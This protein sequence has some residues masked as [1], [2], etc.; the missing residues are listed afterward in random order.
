MVVLA[1]TPLPA[2]LEVAEQIRATCAEGIMVT[3]GGELRITTS[4]GVA[5][6]ASRPGQPENAEDILRRAD[7]ALYQAKIEGR[8]CIR[9][10]RETANL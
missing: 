2:A 9:A 1:G 7:S 4:L 8:N 10:A 5:A 3:R 6:L